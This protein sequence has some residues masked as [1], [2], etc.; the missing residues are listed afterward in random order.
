MGGGGGGGVVSCQNLMHAP[1]KTLNDC[2]SMYRDCSQATS[3]LSMHMCTY[4]HT[5]V[6]ESCQRLCVKNKKSFNNNYHVHACIKGN[7][8]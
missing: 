2:M 1:V 3:G 7:F 4:V 8:V 6:L 5:C